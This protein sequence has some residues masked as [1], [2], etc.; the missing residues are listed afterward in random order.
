TSG[1][2][3]SFTT[4]VPSCSLQDSYWLSRLEMLIRLWCSTHR[5]RCRSLSLIVLRSLVCLWIHSQLLT[6]FVR[7]V[8]RK[9][10]QEEGMK[11]E[12]QQHIAHVH[13]LSHQLG[14]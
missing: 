2:M 6:H 12:R 5:V 4:I 9:E 7:V 11:Y 8:S 13:T 1:K 14:K 3:D 10:E